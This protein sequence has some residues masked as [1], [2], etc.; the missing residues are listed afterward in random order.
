MPRRITKLSLR[1]EG[2][3]A[4]FDAVAATTATTDEAFRALG[5]AAREAGTRRIL[6][7]RRQPS[8]LRRSLRDA[9]RAELR[10]QRRAA[11]A[12]LRQAKRGR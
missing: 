4:A 8:W 6:E 10:K 9:E 1:A 3:P 11:R 7:G 5:I 12:R 2:L